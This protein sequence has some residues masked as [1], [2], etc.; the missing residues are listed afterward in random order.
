MKGILAVTGATGKS[1]RV[2]ARLL[3]ENYDT[4]K[5]HFEGGVRFLVRDG[6]GLNLPIDTR[7][8][9]QCCVG[10]LKDDSFLDRT[11]KDADVILHIAGIKLTA[12]IV[13]AAIKNHVKRLIVVHTTGIYSKYKAAGEEY[14]EIEKYVYR[15]CSENGIILTVLRPTMIYGCMSDKNVATFVKMVDRL[16]VMP[17]VSGG[18]YAL[19]PV[20]YADLGEAYYRVLMN[21]ERIANTDFILSGGAPIMLR[22]MFTEIGKNLGKR[23]RFISCPFVIAYAG[24][25]V[26]FILSLSHIDYREKVQRLCENRTFPYEE[27][28]NAFGYSPRTFQ[29]GIADE[30]R[31]FK[32]EKSADRRK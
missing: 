4:V 26:L 3:V 9:F 7:E 22:D 24:A 27:A 2:L 14:R 13:K 31:E 21:E 12:P 28:R 5:Q 8:Y 10:D 30:V 23:T 18:R 20:H 11:T 6:S 1:G 25:W 19:Q 17:V 16:P 15:Q 29:E 32:A